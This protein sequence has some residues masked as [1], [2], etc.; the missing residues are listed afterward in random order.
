MKTRSLV[1]KF[2]MIMASAILGVTVS[3]AAR[4][5]AT[6][7]SCYSWS[8]EGLD[9]AKMGC[10]H[11]AYTL[12]RRTAITSAGNWGNLEMRYSP[13]C[14][15]NWT[16]FTPWFGIRAFFDGITGGYVGGSPWIYRQG[17]YLSKGVTSSAGVLGFGCTNW[18]AMISANGTT[19]W[20][21]HVYYTAPSSS[22]QGARESLGSYAGPCI[23]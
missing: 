5:S 13:S 1:I 6:P 18:T 14:H 8:C 16:R 7:P 19:C 21:V 2:V 11:D 15:T 9:P 22:G 10:A 17:P 23:S 20:G 12:I 4:A 3:T